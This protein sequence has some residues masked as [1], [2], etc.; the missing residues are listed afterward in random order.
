VD[1][2]MGGIVPST[3]VDCVQQ[4]PQLIRKGLGVWEEVEI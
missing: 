3:I 2:G 1:G 4:P